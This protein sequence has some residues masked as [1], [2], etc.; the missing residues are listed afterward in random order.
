MSSFTLTTIAD[1]KEYLGIDSTTYDDMLTIIIQTVSNEIEIYCNRQF[2]LDSYSEQ[3]NGNGEVHVRLPNTPVEGILYAATGRASL[4]DLTYDGTNTGFIEIQDKEYRL[5]DGLSQSDGTISDTDTIADVAS[6]INADSNFSAT[7]LDDDLGKYPGRCLTQRSYPILESGDNIDL[8][9]PVNTISLREVKDGLYL[10]SR[11]ICGLC[12]VIYNGG[13]AVD[14]QPVGLEQLAT[15]IS[16][17]L[18]KSI[19]QQ[20]NMKSEKIGDYSYTINNNL[21]T[22]MQ[23]YSHRLDFYREHM[24]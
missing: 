7:V 23:A 6:N 21:G 9:G 1:V 3:I 14:G 12:L 22:V 20:A 18:Y 16:A 8:V 10:T 17:D 13:Y 5:V 4:I 19:S 24:I 2:E 15:Q 11:P